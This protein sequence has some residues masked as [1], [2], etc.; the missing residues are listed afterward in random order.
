MNRNA[1]LVRL[2]YY[3]DVWFSVDWDGLRLRCNFVDD[4]TR[5][6]V[7]LKSSSRFRTI[8]V[9]HRECSLVLVLLVAVDF[10]GF[11]KAH[12]CLHNNE[13]R[14]GKFCHVCENNRSR[15]KRLRASCRKR[16][17]A[18]CSW[19]R[20]KLSIDWLEKLHFRSDA[21]WYVAANFSAAF[22]D[23]NYHLCRM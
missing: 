12:V 17:V 1:R 7:R 10:Y 11:H 3:S 21:K 4:F 6:M 8:R 15:R 9:R 22:N 13:A 19:L 5:R 18:N 23:D 14:S 16:V 20:A 2:E